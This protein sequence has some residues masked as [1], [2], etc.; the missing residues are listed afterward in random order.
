MTRSARTPRPRSS[1]SV[2]SRVESAASSRG[3]S[4]V[5]SWRW[6]ADAE[7]GTPATTATAARQASRAM[8]GVRGTDGASSKSD[9]PP[10]RSGARSIC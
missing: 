6:E 4:K 9:A 7:A 3:A 10:Y 2:A 8:S 5:I 1:S